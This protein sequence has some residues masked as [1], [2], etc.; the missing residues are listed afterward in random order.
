[1]VN[2]VDRTGQPTLDNGYYDDDDDDDGVTGDDLISII[3]SCEYTKVA[4]DRS[5]CNIESRA[6]KDN[7]IKLN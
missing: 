6:R 4:R 5:Q 3:E 7:V 1:M 2:F